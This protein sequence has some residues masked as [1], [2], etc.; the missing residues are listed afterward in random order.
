MASKVAVQR[1]AGHYSACGRWCH[2]LCLTCFPPTPFFSSPIKLVFISTVE[3]SQFHFSHFLPTVRSCCR[4]CQQLLA[5]VRCWL[6][7]GAHYLVPCFPLAL[8][9]KKINLTAVFAFTAT[10]QT[11]KHY[12][13]QNS[14][15]L[16]FLHPVRESFNVQYYTVSGALDLHM[17]L[18]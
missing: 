2:L 3:F 17:C 9:G 5:G 10:T 11:Y 18:L 7:E 4:E 13:R 8:K 6:E 12:N 15:C 1:L 14:I 16:E